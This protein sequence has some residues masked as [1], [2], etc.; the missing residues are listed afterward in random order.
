MFLLA[1]ISSFLIT[2]YTTALSVPW[3][4]TLGKHMLIFLFSFVLM[5]AAIF[6][7]AYIVYRL[8]N[9]YFMRQHELLRYLIQFLLLVML[10]G[11]VALRVV[12]ALYLALF[13]VD[14]Q[15][16]E[17]FER[18][19]VV[20]LFCLIMVQVYYAV[21]KERRCRNYARKRYQIMKKWL[22]HGD[23]L[24]KKNAH[25]QVL[26]LKQLEESSSEQQC[27]I[28]RHE[29]Q[30]D[31]LAVERAQ[32]VKL[33]DKQMHE[34]RVRKQRLRSNHELLSRDEMQLKRCLKELNDEILV[35][36]GA[37]N[38][39][40]RIPQIAYFYLKVGS[41]RSKLVDVLLLDGREGKV[42]LESLAKIEKLWPNL[43]FRVGRGRLIMHLAIRSLCKEG[44]MHFIV[45]YGAQQER[46]KVPVDV[47]EK[48]LKIRAE[49]AKLM[50]EK[51]VKFT[52]GDE[53]IP[54]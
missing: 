41:S 45:F 11:A 34:L 14:L 54:R 43:L 25:D 17:Y 23:E 9:D 3:S 19:Y 12:Y 18:D 22:L 20:V 5:V 26:L 7:T 30:L 44:D 36:I 38:E 51:S 32:L 35:I 42:D 27:L 50:P 29:A 24:L 39:W 1:A 37:E 46:Y 16:A 10:L 21:R 52:I 15:K 13:R 2:F 47:Y 49:W 53:N 4:L 40:V 6:P 33:Y 28:L 48:L 31:Q 8:D